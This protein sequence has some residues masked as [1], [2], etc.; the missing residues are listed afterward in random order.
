MC[1][2]SF[3]SR[4]ENGIESF[5]HITTDLQQKHNSKVEQMNNLSSHLKTNVYNSKLDL[6][7]LL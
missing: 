1:N 4:V 7:S 6:K 5:R 2:L 3:Q